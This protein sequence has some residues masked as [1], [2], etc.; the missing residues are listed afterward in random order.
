MAFPV[1]E[2]SCGIL[3]VHVCHMILRT[4]GKEGVSCL[5]AC[6]YAFSGES[7]V[8][9]FCCIAHKQTAFL[10]YVSFEVCLL[11]KTFITQRA[12]IGPFTSM[13]FDVRLKALFPVS[14]KWTLVT[15]KSRRFVPFFMP[16]QRAFAF[17]CLFA[18]V[19]RERYNNV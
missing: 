17:E 9:T 7:F 1:Y 13:S 15:R 19:T 3:N 18:Q 8:K 10:H 12:I 5:C 6:H 2:F 14:G 4:L 16:T 11:G